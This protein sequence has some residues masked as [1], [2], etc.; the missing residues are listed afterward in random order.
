MRYR[1]AVAMS[2][3]GT[4]AAG[5]L[6]AW[7]YRFRSHGESL[8]SLRVLFGVALFLLSF[9]LTLVWQSVS[10]VRSWSWL[11]TFAGFSL[12][13]VVVC[14]AMVVVIRSIPW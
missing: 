14:I 8:T 6:C 9:A 1:L 3:T 7:V 4:I 11:T 5:F 12:S 2:K 10:K 13:A